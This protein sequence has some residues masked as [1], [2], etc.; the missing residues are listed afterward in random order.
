[1]SSFAQAVQTQTVRTTNGMK[2]H[3]GTSDACVDLFYKIGALRNGDPIPPFTAAF[4]ENPD[5][6][7]RILQWGRDVRGGAGEREVFRKILK[8]LEKTNPEAVAL[9]IPKIPEI[10]RFDDLFIFTNPEL[11]AQAF[12]LYGEYLRNG[13]A[14]AAK[15]A[16]REKSAKSSCT[17]DSRWWRISVSSRAT[18]SAS[19]CGVV[20]VWYSCG[21]SDTVW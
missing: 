19:C 4:A 14:L 12:T 2:A 7:L 16:P 11:K 1:M 6:A 3:A 21:V 17:P 20:T 13:N 5:L 18:R 10:G 9:I 15:W 8:S